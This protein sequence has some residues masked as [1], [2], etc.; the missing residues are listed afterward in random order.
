MIGAVDY[1][2]VQLVSLTSLKV[3]YVL[4]YIQKNRLYSSSFWRK[5]NWFNLAQHYQLIRRSDVA[6]IWIIFIV[7]GKAKYLAYW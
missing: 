6:L 3:K 4:I 5:S 1:N 7:K 2:C